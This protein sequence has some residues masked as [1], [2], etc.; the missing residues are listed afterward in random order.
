MIRPRLLLREY[1]KLN[2]ERRPLILEEELKAMEAKRAE[3]EKANAMTIGRWMPICLGLKEMKDKDS[4]DR[5]EQIAKHIV[6]LMGNTLLAE[7]S[8]DDLFNYRDARRKETLFRCGEWTKVPVSDGCIRN[9]LALL[10]RA[11]NLARV[12]KESKAKDGIKYEVSTVSF[13]GVMPEP[14][15]RQRV[16]SDSERP[17]L[18]KECPLWLQWLLIVAL[19]TCISIGDLLRLRLEDIDEEGG[20][21]VPDG[22]RLKTEVRQAAPLTEAV[23]K[24]LTEIKRERQRSKVR[25]LETSHLVFVREDGSAITYNSVYKAL[26]R[27]C[28][29]AGVKDFRFH[30][31]R[32]HS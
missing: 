32:P 7:I 13:D 25:N 28:K 20:V 22:G 15:H 30:D 5:D 14:N 31:T 27:A 16:L 8:R 26:H 11:L 1:E 10:R 24:V 29:R 4:T 6:R 19:E 2:D 12:Y 18:L 17:K 23:K 9:E 21:I 3:E